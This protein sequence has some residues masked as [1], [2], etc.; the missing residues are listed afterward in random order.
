MNKT[1]KTK[2]LYSFVKRFAAARLPATQ[3]CSSRSTIVT[4]ARVTHSFFTMS[5]VDGWNFTDP[6]FYPVAYLWWC[7]FQTV[8]NKPNQLACL[9][10][11]LPFWKNGF[12]PPGPNVA[13]AF[14]TNDWFLIIFSMSS[15]YLF[16]PNQTCCRLIN[17]ACHYS[18]H[19]YK[20]N[21]KLFK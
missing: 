12:Q 8:C 3:G 20:T 19:N 2:F 17:K 11:C 10:I 14:P 13:G 7:W 18:I 16:V 21:I 6:Q 15:V 5:V 4:L 9:R 1:W